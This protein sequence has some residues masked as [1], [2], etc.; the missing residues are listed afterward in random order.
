MECYFQPRV[1]RIYF[2]YFILYIWLLVHF[3]NLRS[4]LPCRLSTSQLCCSNIWIMPF[5]T[6]SHTKN[7]SR[8]LQFIEHNIVCVCVDQESTYRSTVGL[9]LFGTFVSL[10]EKQFGWMEVWGK[11]E[12]RYVLSLVSFL[13][14]ASVIF[15]IDSHFERR[16]ATAGAT[17]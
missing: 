6:F 8:S 5:L 15:V 2:D 17:H 11:R 7:Y 3:S 1:P 10:Y 13:L 14:A 12:R 16:R 4:L 9:T